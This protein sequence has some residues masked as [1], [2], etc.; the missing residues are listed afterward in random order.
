MLFKILPFLLPALLFSIPG[1]HEPWGK[2][3]DLEWKAPQE[4]PPADLSLP[5]HA[6]EKVIWF[7]QNIISPCDGPRSHYKPSSSSYMLQAIR[8]HGFFKGYVMGCD[9]L[10]RE[11]S[12]PWIY[13]T[14]VIDNKIWKTDPP[15]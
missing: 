11:N 14:T 15:P 5:A 7:H 8:K 12:D 13:R 1:Y 2:D 10:L 6:M 4:N 9:R 3:T